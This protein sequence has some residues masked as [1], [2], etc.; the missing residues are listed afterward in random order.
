MIRE[1]Q[2]SFGVEKTRFQEELLR[3]FE[4]FLDA[5]VQKPCSP[6]SVVAQIVFSRLKRSSC[7]FS[8]GFVEDQFGLGL[9]A[10]ALE[11]SIQVIKPAGSIIMNM[12][13]RPG[14]AVLE[15]LYE[16]R[17]FSIRKVCIFLFAVQ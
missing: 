5:V 17:G 4:M 7:A 12:G 16:R 2:E 15:R 3:R 14:Q 13:G 9:I 6:S 1:L 11:E 10:R 8:Q